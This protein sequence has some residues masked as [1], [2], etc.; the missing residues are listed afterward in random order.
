[1]WISIRDKAAR[2]WHLNSAGLT[3]F[4]RQ[5]VY[6]ELLNEKSQVVRKTER[7]DLSFGIK[8]NGPELVSVETDFDAIRK[9]RD[10]RS[11]VLHKKLNHLIQDNGKKAFD[12]LVQMRLHLKRNQDELRRKQQVASAETMSNVNRLVAKAKCGE[13]VATVVRDLSATV[14][15]VGAAFLTG[16]AA[17]GVLGTGSALKG[18][19]KYEESGNIGAGVLEASGTFVVGLINVAPALAESGKAVTLAQRWAPAAGETSVAILLIG[20]QT[21]AALEVG[22]SAIDGASAKEAFEKGGVRFLTDVASGGVGMKLDA[23]RLLG[24]TGL[25]VAARLVTDATMAV[26][27]D[28]AVKH[29]GASGHHTE[30]HSKIKAAR[31]CH[32]VI[33]RMHT[34]GDY[35]RALVLRPA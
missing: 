19:G 4:T 28:E 13:E 5:Y 16:G 14:L 33:P 32:A 22:K 20:A 17:A 6:A 12:E 10:V 23:V 30:H 21:D 25:P 15:V 29:T 34:D 9:A 7:I 1:M 26:A 8:V 3:T 27:S 31:D 35:I 24:K 18:V 2:N 11:H